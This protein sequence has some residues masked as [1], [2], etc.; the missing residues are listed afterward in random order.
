MA[1]NASPAFYDAKDEQPVAMVLFDL[2]QLSFQGGMT[3]FF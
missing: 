2:K 1:S 3:G